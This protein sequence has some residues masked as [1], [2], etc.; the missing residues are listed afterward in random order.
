[1]HM[2]LRNAM[3]T[4]ENIWKNWKIYKKSWKSENTSEI[5]PEN[6]PENT[7]ENT[8][9]K[10]YRKNIS[11]EKNLKSKNSDLQK[12]NEIKKKSSTSKKWY[13]KNNLRKKRF[14]NKI[15]G[16]WP[17]SPNMHTSRVPAFKKNNQNSME[18]PQQ[19]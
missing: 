6:T 14:Q 2:H 13:G 1:M 18:R 12:I 17:V 16:L 11:N 15:W 9:Q 8:P 4:S 5:T 19:R 3:K 10:T 7:S